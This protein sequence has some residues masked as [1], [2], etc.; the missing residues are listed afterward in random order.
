MIATP[1]RRRLDR[2]PPARAGVGRGRTRGAPSSCAQ[3]S[4]PVGRR[5]PDHRVSPSCATS[6][7]RRRCISTLPIDVGAARWPMS[8]IRAITL[9]VPSWIALRSSGRSG[10]AD[11]VRPS[12]WQPATAM[13][14]RQQARQTREEHGRR[15]ITGCPAWQPLREIAVASGSFYPNVIRLFADRRRGAGVAPLC[16]GFA[17][18]HGSR[19][20]GRALVT[21][22]GG[23][24]QVADGALVRPLRQIRCGRRLPDAGGGPAPP[25]AT[26]GLG[27]SAC[28]TLEAFGWR[29]RGGQPAFR[30][31]R[32]AEDRDDWPRVV[33]AC[34]EALAADPGHLDAAWLLAVA[35]AKL[36]KLDRGARAA[37]AGRRR[38]L[39]QV[40]PG[41]ARAPERC[42]RSSRR[43]PARRGGAGSSSIARRYVA[44]LARAA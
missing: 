9:R 1:V 32:K 16:R 42:S 20:P 13:P 10:L 21:P 8:V 25:T 19:W 39:R 43:R 7:D 38:R 26:A 3:W 41:V 34:H 37:A 29:K 35:L 24:G 22:P 5:S 23:K 27:R 2:T 11:P 31:A 28:R 17:R 33:D 18:S 44:A 15:F 14:Q 36:G 6:G 4:R 12:P 40:G 30:V